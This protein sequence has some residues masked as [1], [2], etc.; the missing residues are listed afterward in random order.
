MVFYVH[1]YVQIRA[2][3][4]LWNGKSFVVCMEEMEGQ[5]EAKYTYKTQWECC[6]SQAEMLHLLTS[7]SD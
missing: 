6:Q 7:G 2:P 4:P 3:V 1:H 5:K